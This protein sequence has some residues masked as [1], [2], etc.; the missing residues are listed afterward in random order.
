MARGRLEKFSRSLADLGR[1]GLLTKSQAV[2][3]AKRIVPFIS[4]DEND[5]DLGIFDEEDPF[6]GWGEIG[7]LI[8]F[9]KMCCTYDTNLTKNL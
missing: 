4:Q 2:L 7:H 9:L 8:M 6:S 1:S 5:W 3:L